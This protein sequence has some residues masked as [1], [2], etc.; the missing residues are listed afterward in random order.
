MALTGLHRYNVYVLANRSTDTAAVSTKRSWY[1]LLKRPPHCARDCYREYTARM[2]GYCS[3]EV[4]H[5]SPRNVRYLKLRTERPHKNNPVVKNMPV[6]DIQ[7]R[8]PFKA[9]KTNDITA[10]KQIPE[11]VRVSVMATT[12]PDELKRSGS[13]NRDHRIQQNGGNS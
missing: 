6:L 2:I 10:S 7:G 9:I 11:T 1:C 3:D 12:A 13:Y 8:A 4:L 5:V